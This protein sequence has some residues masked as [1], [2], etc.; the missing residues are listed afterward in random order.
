MRSIT[1]YLDVLHSLVEFEE[2][3]FSASQ[4]EDHLPLIRTCLLDLFLTRSAPFL[5][6]L[7]LHNHSQSVR[8]H[9]RNEAA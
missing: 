4:R 8:V 1:V 6:R 2:N 7:P 5:W 3:D 9:L